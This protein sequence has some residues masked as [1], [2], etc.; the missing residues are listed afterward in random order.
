MLLVLPESVSCGVAGVHPILYPRLRFWNGK[1][2]CLG[3][4][5][6]YAD[7]PAIDSLMNRCAHSVGFLK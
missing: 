4:N 7:V 5:L 3:G 1:D 2:G 6:V